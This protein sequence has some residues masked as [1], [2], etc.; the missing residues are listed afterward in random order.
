MFLKIGNSTGPIS[1]LQKMVREALAD[2]GAIIK[3]IDDHRSL[4]AECEALAER[5][6]L[7]GLNQDV[8]ASA[9]ATRS[10]VFACVLVF[11][12]PISA[13]RSAIARAG[14]HIFK[15]DVTY[16][17]GGEFGEVSELSIT[18]TGLD[19]LVIAKDIPEELAKVA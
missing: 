19:C 15:E 13:V 3:A 9:I 10:T 11:N 6:S 17:V 16:D 8:S 7:H 2:A 18:L 14:L 5:L 4:I 12:Q 1:L